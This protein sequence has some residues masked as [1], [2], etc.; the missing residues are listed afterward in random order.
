VRLAVTVAAFAWV[1][2]RV[3]LP[4]VGSAM[5]RAP[6]WAFAAAVALTAGNLGIGA[7]RWRALLAAY[8]APH[9]PPLLR[10]YRLNFVGLFYN[11]WLPGGVG[12]EL[13]RGVASRE[14]FGEGGTTGAM[15]VVFVE[16]VLGLVGLL[17]LVATTSLARPLAGVTGVLWGSAAG[18]AAGLA[19][20]GGLALGRTIARWLPARLRPI[21]ERLPRIERPL[22]FLFAAA[23]S[24]VTHSVVAVTGHLFAAALAPEVPLSTS[25]VIVPLA[26]ATAY[27]PITIGGAGAREAV[28][29]QLYGA[30]GVSFED[31]TAVSLLLTASSY[32]TAAIGG[33]LPI[34]TALESSA[35]A[36]HRRHCG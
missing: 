6:L 32:L 21:A 12:G 10:L 19:A 23:L 33:L 17:L 14:A 30:V 9:R 26:M 34:A 4:A 7:L 28:F 5:A 8:G 29:Q 25:F 24:L 11:L 22:P 13:V 15:A 2:S 20:I 16:R 3:D 36:E 27:I 1:F 31:A 35:S 18:I